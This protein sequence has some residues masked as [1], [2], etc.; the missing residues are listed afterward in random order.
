MKSAAFFTSLVTLATISLLALP[1]RCASQTAAPASPAA[2]ATAEA[3]ADTLA[4]LHGDWPAG[5]YLV[6]LSPHDASAR[7][8]RVESFTEDL[9][10]I[11]RPSHLKG[12]RDLVSLRV[13][14]GSRVRVVDLECLGTPSPV[15]YREVAGNGAFEKGFL[16][17]DLRTERKSGVKW[18][19][20]H[21]QAKLRVAE[22]LDL[23]GK[24]ATVRGTRTDPAEGHVPTSMV[25]E[26]IQHD[27]SQL[28]IRIQESW[29]LP[30]GKW[31]K[32]A[33][34]WRFDRDGVD[35]ETGL[36]RWKVRAG[37]LLPPGKHDNRSNWRGYVLLDQG[38][39]VGRYGFDWEG[40]E[41][42][43]HKPGSAELTHPLRLTITPAGHE[44]A[45]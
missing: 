23:L 4:A 32:P 34:D 45:Q 38:Q 43:G 24:G 28:V 33:Y 19:P 41:K 7:F 30:N 36:P 18:M 15:V 26:V 44:V 16:R 20:Q 3:P 5:A 11:S 37:K 17:L 12:A 22:D 27:R 31:A 9:L 42:L 10:R 35:T 25:G 39:L 8:W 21:M 14:A 6:D 29:K 13:L 1:R 2:P 40:M